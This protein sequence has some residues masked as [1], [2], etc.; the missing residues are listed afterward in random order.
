MFLFVSFL[1]EYMGGDCTD[2]SIV[3]PLLFIQSRIL[4]LTCG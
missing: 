3:G 1:F 4:K 2:N